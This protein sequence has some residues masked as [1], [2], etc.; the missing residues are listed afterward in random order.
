MVG[1]SRPV[2]VHRS[3]I[4][5]MER[6]FAY[7]IEVHEGAFPVWYAP[8]QLEVLPIGPEQH[9]VAAAFTRAAVEAGLRAELAADGSLGARVRAAARRRVPYAAVIG[10]RE[11]AE[12]LV[13]LR[14]RDGRALDPMPGQRRA[15]P[16]DQRGN[17]PLR[18]PAT[19]LTAP[20]I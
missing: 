19:S 14:L 6:L 1:P 17:H 15:A 12:G 13:S 8:V 16:G 10:P 18:R 7:L 3:L 20:A 5:S 4:G 2:I 11:A 9:D